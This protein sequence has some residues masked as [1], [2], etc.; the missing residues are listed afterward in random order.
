MRGRCFV[1]KWLDQDTSR[2]VQR[3]KHASGAVW[4]DDTKCE[5]PEERK[6]K[7][8]EMRAAWMQVFSY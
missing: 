8:D 2:L 3:V 1:L 6:S 7:F 5:F 4:E